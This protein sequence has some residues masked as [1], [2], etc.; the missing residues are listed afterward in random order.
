MEDISSMVWKYS[1][2]F[3]AVIGI[4]VLIY[5][6]FFILDGFYTLADGCPGESEWD[7]VAKACRDPNCK[8]GQRGTRGPSGMIC[9]KTRSEL[10]T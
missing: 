4:I 3:L 1:I 8:P 5:R 10:T 9:K 6:S 7:D 2:Y